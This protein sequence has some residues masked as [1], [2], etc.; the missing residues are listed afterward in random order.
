MSVFQGAVRGIDPDRPRTNVVRCYRSEGQR[1]DGALLGNCSRTEKSGF[2]CTAI[3]VV[4]RSPFVLG[5]GN[6]R[7]EAE[8]H[9]EGVE[10]ISQLVQRSEI[11]QGAD[12]FVPGY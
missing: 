1:V 3:Q 8:C 6:Q 2:K 9:V 12:L 10:V 5:F 4:E 11:K 7:V